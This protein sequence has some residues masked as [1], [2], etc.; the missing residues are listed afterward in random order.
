MI[1]TYPVDSGKFYAVDF[2]KQRFDNSIKGT[3]GAENA[4]LASFI[5]HSCDEK[6]TNLLA[7]KGIVFRNIYQF[8]YKSWI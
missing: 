3:A 1:S 5:D 2:A 8:D 4:H 7:V 6:D